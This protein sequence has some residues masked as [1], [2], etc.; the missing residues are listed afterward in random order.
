[1]GN[2]GGGEICVITKL[3][4]VIR[5]MKQAE[6]MLGAGRLLSAVFRDSTKNI[7]LAIAALEEHEERVAKDTYDVKGICHI[8]GVAFQ[9]FYLILCHPC[10]PQN[11]F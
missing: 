6:R 3:L 7:I 9:F 2:F 11:H 5:L 1:M 10:D 8:R 4:L